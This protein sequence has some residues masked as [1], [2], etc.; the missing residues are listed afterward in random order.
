[1]A[2]TKLQEK[3]NTSLVTI[4]P[5]TEIATTASVAFM[6]IKKAIRPP[7]IKSETTK[8]AT[9]VTSKNSKRRRQRNKKPEALLIY[10]YIPEHV[11]PINNKN[12]KLGSQLR[13]YSPGMFTY[14]SNG[15]KGVELATFLLDT[16]P[17]AETLIVSLAVRT[18]DIIEMQSTLVSINSFISCRN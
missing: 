5:P 9:G 12:G 1:M 8:A 6:A 11:Q 14:R 7:Q 3:Q 13:E 15:R 2:Q 4:S 17:Y 10:P 18:N 16:I